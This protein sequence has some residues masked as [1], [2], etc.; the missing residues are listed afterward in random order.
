M[1]KQPVDI[2]KVLLNVRTPFSQESIAKKYGVE[3][4][5]VQTVFDS[6]VENGYRFV[7]NNGLYLR[8]KSPSVIFN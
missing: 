5:Q 3:I 8:S 6:L 4:E 7:E 2:N 1:E